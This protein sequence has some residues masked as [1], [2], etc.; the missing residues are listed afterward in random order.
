MM[1]VPEKYRLLDHP[2]LATTKADGNNGAFVIR[3]KERELWIIVSDGS[4]W[5][6]AG[7]TGDKWEHVSVHVFD[8]KRTV[9]PRWDEM[10]FVKD[11]FWDEEDVVVQFHPKKS[12]YINNHPNTLHLWRIIDKEFPTPP[13]EAV[14]I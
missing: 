10:C 5:E 2:V 8:G 3:R 1:H 14:G 11:L 6:E 13:K 9:T 12:E 4:L 7:F